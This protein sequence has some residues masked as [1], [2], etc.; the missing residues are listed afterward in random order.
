MLL[1]GSLVAAALP[2]VIAI[3][4]VGSTLG[5][6]VLAS[7]LT[8]I[9]DF[10]APLMMLVGLGVGIDYA[11]LVFSRFRAE[12]I[13]GA[14]RGRRRRDRRAHRRPDDRMLEQFGLGLAVAVFLDAVVIRCLLL[15]ALMQLLGRAAWWLPV[16]RR[17]VS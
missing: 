16:R 14:S 11:L 10:T 4:A 6:I 8:P 12:L 13:G 17:R 9:A 1:F 3:F 5:L 15:P 2:I 7:R